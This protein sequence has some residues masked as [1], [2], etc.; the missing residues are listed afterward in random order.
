M[1]HDALDQALNYIDEYSEPELLEM[2][3][4]HTSFNAWIAELCQKAHADG[5][6]VACSLY[7][8]A[9]ARF[10]KS[11]ARRCEPPSA[12]SAPEVSATPRWSSSWSGRSRG[13][14]CSSTPSDAAA[15]RR[16]FTE[17]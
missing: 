6:T 8:R 15:P 12:S 1:A 4:K 7:I 14:A 3:L 10:S 17:R 2:A 11:S 9:L 5:V 16:P 13:S